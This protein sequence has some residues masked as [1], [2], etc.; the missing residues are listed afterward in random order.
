[1]KRTHRQRGFLSDSRSAVPSFW[2]KGGSQTD[3]S[4]RTDDRLSTVGCVCSTRRCSLRTYF[5]NP[6]V[7]HAHALSSMVLFHCFQVDQGAST[8]G[9]HRDCAFVSVFGALRNESRCSAFNCSGT[10]RTRRWR[11]HCAQRTAISPCW[12]RLDFEEDHAEDADIGPPERRRAFRTRPKQ[13]DPKSTRD[14]KHPRVPERPSA[15]VT[16]LPSESSTTSKSEKRKPRTRAALKT[17]PESKPTSPAV[18]LPHEPAPA[19]TQRRSSDTQGR[20]PQGHWSQG[21]GPPP[22]D[23]HPSSIAP[24]NG[25]ETARRE[26]SAS[27][28]GLGR[29]A[30]A[31]SR[32]GSV[33]G[34]KPT[35]D[36]RPDASSSGPGSR[37]AVG[38]RTPDQSM[39]PQEL[40]KLANT[41]RM[42]SRGAYRHR[43]RGN[44]I[45]RYSSEPQTLSPRMQELLQ[46]LN[47]DES[48]FQEAEII[49]DSEGFGAVSYTS[50]Y[51]RV[52]TETQNETS[53]AS[54]APNTDSA[55]K[56]NRNK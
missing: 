4:R 15:S 38:R 3:P 19:P 21:T 8:M 18:P 52:I 48:R 12:M 9:A 32:R 27:A 22:S 10:C 42:T 53:N 36:K 29:D 28:S 55:P 20:H 25:L 47:F 56:K 2:R 34:A 6:S 50:C 51:T 43:Y 44:Q 54:A 7:P 24:S 39:A 33:P 17:P 5:T 23:P 13:R 16:P 11:H 41:S 31:G 26:S 45:P 46:R 37:S 14:L 1:V 49:D 30:T 35:A 40:K